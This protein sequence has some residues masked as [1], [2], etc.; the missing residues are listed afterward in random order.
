[1][2][3]THFVSTLAGTA[4]MVAAPVAARAARFDDAA[5]GEFSG[6][7]AV[8][9]GPQPVWQRAYGQANRADGVANAPATRFNVGS[10]CKMFTSALVTSNV[11]AGRLRLDATV[12]D[13]LPAYPNEAVRRTVTIRQ[14]LDMR[15]GVPDFFNQRYQQLNH[16]D[17]DTLEDYLPFFADLPLEFEPGTKQA[18]SNGGYLI[19]GLVIQAVENASYYQAVQRKI[20][21]VAGMRGAGFFGLSEVVPR[22]ATGYVRDQKS[23]AWSTNLAVLPGKGSSAGGGYATAAD[24][25]LFVDALQRGTLA[26]EVPGE[27][28]ERSGVRFTLGGGAP[29]VHALVHAG[30]AGRYTAVVLANLSPP[31]AGPVLAALER[32]LAS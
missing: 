21:D 10:L 13:Y 9:E 22:I 31:A 19:L 8:F 3:R 2:N 11:R 12:G 4:A 27:R 17:I 5:S 15:G 14:L 29:G 20:F 1:M 6:V 18:Y 28:G 32:A 7:A 30:V 16:A 23:G 25:A 26:M 24:L